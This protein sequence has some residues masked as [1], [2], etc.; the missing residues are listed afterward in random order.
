[1]LP[2]LSGFSIA[3]IPSLRLRQ[4]AFLNLILALNAV[5]VLALVLPKDIHLEIFRITER[6]PI[7]IKVD[8][9][10]RFF[11]SLSSLMLL[12]VGI[13]SPAYMSHEAG[14]ARFNMFY[15]IVLGLLNGLGLSGNLMTLY[16][17][18]EL[19][20]LFSVPL[21]LHSMENVAIAAA[22]KYLYYSIAGAS[23]ALISFFFYYAY[24]TTLEFTPGGVLDVTKLAGREGQILAVSLLAIIGLSA[25]AG[26]FPLHAWLPAAHTAAPAPASAVLSG[27]ITKAGV[28]AVF[29]FVFYIAGPDF[30]RGTWVQTTWISLSL[31]TVIMGA[32]LAF[33]EPQLKRLLAYSTISQLGYI[34]FGLATLTTAGIKGALL[35]IVFHS[36]AKDALFLIAG[37]IIIKTNKINVS[38]LRGIG[39]KI[40]VTI[41]CFAV[42]AV[43]I[44]GIPPTSGFVSKWYLATGSLA[45]DTGFIA[46][47]GPAILLLAALLSA[48]YML[49]IAINA[50]FPGAGYESEYTRGSN[51]KNLLMILPIVL[52]T[53]AALAF[54]II[55]GPL[56]SFFDGIIKVIY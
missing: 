11:C 8:G 23:L 20:T 44:I 47:F 34:L 5:S 10:A 3:L 37:L 21:V 16:L 9:P 22:F 39:M 12:L 38:D 13:Y 32:V 51:E 52:L 35:H 31:F 24:G 27:V 4:H 25:K 41:C 36:I 54:G 33:K 7:I 30:L 17:F 1:M 26:M 40:P 29:R 48:G 19:M 14:P 43:T 6:L 42:L 56:L 45:S 50:F 53:L 55:P 28:F 18:F 49:P 46:W 15:L 2:V